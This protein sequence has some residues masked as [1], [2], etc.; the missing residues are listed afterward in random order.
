MVNKTLLKNKLSEKNFRQKW[1]L[2][3]MYILVTCYSEKLNSRNS[4][5][6]EMLARSLAVPVVSVTKTYFS[7]RN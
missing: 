3:Q 2:N 4:D 5:L 1:K 7:T 6:L